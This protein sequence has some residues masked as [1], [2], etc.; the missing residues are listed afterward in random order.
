MK[1]PW[2][3]CFG[4]Y[5]IRVHSHHHQSAQEPPHPSASAAHFVCL[6]PTN[7]EWTHFKRT[8]L[9]IKVSGSF[10]HHQ[11]SPGGFSTALPHPGSELSVQPGPT[12]GWWECRPLSPLAMLRNS[13]PQHRKARVHVYR[14]WLDHGFW[15]NF[16][17]TEYNVYLCWLGCRKVGVF[18]CIIWARLIKL[19]KTVSLSKFQMYICI[20]S[21]LS[22]QFC[23]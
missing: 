13:I 5:G 22:Q 8:V 9:K 18:N 12:K 21:L 14:D 16:L 19:Q 2:L 20:M 3:Q 6:L 11:G 4:S 15:Y 23:S 7:L 10:K 17:G 1:L